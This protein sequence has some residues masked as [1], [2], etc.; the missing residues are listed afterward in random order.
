MSDMK[1]IFKIASFTMMILALISGSNTIKGSS[2]HT[3]FVDDTTGV[4]KYIELLPFRLAVV[5]P[6]SGVQFF[7]D[8]IV[9]LSM[10]RNESR[11]AS[12]QI[13]FGSVEAYT[14]FTDDTSTISHKLFSRLES[15]SYPC[16]A[17]SFNEAFDTVYFTMIPKKGKKEKIFFAGISRSGNNESELSTQPVPL[18]FCTGNFTYSHPALSADGKMLVFA[19]DREGSLGGM[20]LFLSRKNG[21]KWSEPEN[22]GKSVNTEG[23][24]FYP[25]L[26]KDNNLYFSSDRLPGIGGYD[27]FSCR[28]NGTGWDKPADLKAPINSDQDDIAFVISK[29][30]GKSAFFTRRLRFGTGDLQVY[31][32]IIKPDFKENEKMNL[33]YIFNGAPVPKATFTA[34]LA[35]NTAKQTEKDFARPI[36][37][38]VTVKNESAK[39]H[40]ES[41][42]NK[43]LSAADTTGKKVKPVYPPESKTVT[44]PVIPEKKNPPVITETKPVVQSPL[45]S[46]KTVITYKLQLLPDQAQLKAKEMVILGVTYKIDKYMYTGAVRY[47]IGEYST[48]KEAANLQR[49]CRQNGYAQSFVVAFKNNERSLDPAL[50]K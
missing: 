27:I 40:N 3:P 34:T 37:E 38:P 2:G 45:P 43:Q 12:K 29:T 18:D 44:K 7:R 22:M 6:S 11:M 10:T 8:R 9:F 36:N 13:S 24:E 46:E 19:S 33:G 39:V 17:L 42:T 25:F 32:I 47:T 48:L 4:L 5:P 1:K 35:A 23:N 15:F 20:D 30:D 16:E 28:Y 50:F 26:D 21:T 49:I 31:H 14:A 41:K